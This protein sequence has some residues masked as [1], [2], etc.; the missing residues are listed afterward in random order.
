MASREDYVKTAQVLK[1]IYSEN[2]DEWGKI[3]RVEVD[4]H[5]L[6]IRFAD[7]YAEDNPRFDKTK[8]LYASVA[9]R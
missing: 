4:F 6:V 7:M 5:D 8:F 3:G 9:L 2:M 1:Q